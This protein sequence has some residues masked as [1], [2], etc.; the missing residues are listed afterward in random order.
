MRNK[1]L[2][3]ILLL[4]ISFLFVLS[5]I[6]AV[7]GDLYACPSTSAGDT[8]ILEVTVVDAAGLEDIFGTGWKTVLNTSFSG[9]ASTLGAKLKTVVQ[10]IRNNDT[11][12]YSTYGAGV[13]TVC[14]ITVDSWA[15]TTGEFLEANKTTS[16]VYVMRDPANLTAYVQG[17][18]A[19]LHYYYPLVY[20]EGNVTVPWAY[21]GI[22]QNA[23]L[24]QVPVPPDDYL[25]DII[26]DDGWYSSGANIIHDVTAGYT[27][28]LT[29]FTYNEDCTESWTYYDNGAL[30]AYSLVNNESKV[31]YQ[32]S[33]V[34]PGAAIPG[35][36]LSLFIG[37]SVIT[38]IVLVLYMKR[39]R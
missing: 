3:S 4:V 29:G 38:M 28:E 11:I 8:K 10:G 23:Y 6:V 35:Y 13:V 34:L 26:W 36:E 20:S 15:F 27:V 39:K 16:Q 17:V 14:N 24:A 12:D 9:D 37:V 18:R 31:V 19:F 2:N 33:I 21:D 30:I 32:Y 1:K 5:P 7:R 22:L 25:A